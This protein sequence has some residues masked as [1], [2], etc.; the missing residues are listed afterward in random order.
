MPPRKKPASDR[1]WIKVDKTDDCWVWTGA[2]GDDGYGRFGDQS[3]TRMAHRWAYEHC[4][5][6][7]PAGLQLDHLCHTRDIAA[8]VASGSCLH[9]RC[10]NPDHL[11]PVTRLENVRRG[12]NATLLN[13]HC[14]FGH[15]FTPENTYRSKRGSRECRACSLARSTGSY[16]KAKAS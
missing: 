14:G 12:A 4:V 5:G 7:I 8:C 13:T 9:R 1:F 15:E 16:W 3:R 11:E 2:L 6:P 10:V